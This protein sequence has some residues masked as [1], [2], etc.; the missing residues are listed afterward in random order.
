MIDCIFD[1]GSIIDIPY[2]SRDYRLSVCVNHSMVDK[3]LIGYR[4]LHSIFRGRGH[5]GIPQ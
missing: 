1:C 3:S 5:P 2:Y 4:V